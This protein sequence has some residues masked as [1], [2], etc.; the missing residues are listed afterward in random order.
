M[1]GRLYKEAISIQFRKA[2]TAKDAKDAKKEANLSNEERHSF[3]RN[4][5]LF[6]RQTS[7]RTPSFALLGSFAVNPD[8]NAFLR[9]TT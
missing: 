3:G 4:E 1:N 9:P 5:W 2:F 6:G 8:L 7:D